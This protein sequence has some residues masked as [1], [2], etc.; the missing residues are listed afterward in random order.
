MQLPI[1]ITTNVT[2]EELKIFVKQ[3]FIKQFKYLK[4]FFYIGVPLILL[5]TYNMLQTGAPWSD[6]VR[7]GVF[8]G[9]LFFVWKFIPGS[10]AKNIYK[11]KKDDFDHSVYTFSEESVSVK[12]ATV[13]ATLNWDAFKKVE[14]DENFLWI[15]VTA[16]QTYILPTRC[17]ET[18][19]ILDAVYQL[20][21]SKIK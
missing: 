6:F 17:F 19:E 16:N 11:Q 21:K 8:V 10:N 20:A 4:Y 18:E 15:F 2:Q 12:S 7:V 13:E 3:S 14:K 9:V 1:I 5:N